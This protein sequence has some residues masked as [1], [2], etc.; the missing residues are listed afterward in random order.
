MTYDEIR[1]ALQR[2]RHLRTLHTKRMKKAKAEYNRL[3]EM[4]PA[5]SLAEAAK[6]RPDMVNPRLGERVCSNYDGPVL[7]CVYDGDS[8]CVFCG[9]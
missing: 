6:T 1:R 7:Y 2:Q 4:Y 5:V 3:F 8:P 9:K